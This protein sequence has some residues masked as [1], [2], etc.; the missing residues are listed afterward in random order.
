MSSDPLKIVV[1]I[2]VRGYTSGQFINIEIDVQNKSNVSVSKFLAELIQVR[3]ECMRNN[4]I[5]N[6]A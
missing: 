6:Y 1:R 5:F 3:N 2:P 4:L